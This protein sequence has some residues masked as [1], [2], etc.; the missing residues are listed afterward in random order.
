MHTAVAVDHA[1]R[2]VVMHAR[3]PHQVPA[4]GEIL[5]PPGFFIKQDPQPSEAEATDLKAQILRARLT[6]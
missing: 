1:L 6:L 3:R 5:R 4:T 2:R